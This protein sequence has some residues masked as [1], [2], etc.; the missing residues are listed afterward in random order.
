V[1]LRAP[2]WGSRLTAGSKAGGRSASGSGHVIP[3]LASLTARHHVIPVNPEDNFLGSLPV[4]ERVVETAD[5][6]V[7]DCAMSELIRIERF[8]SVSRRGTYII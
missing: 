2:K 8:D 6:F 5:L 7:D 3:R 4:I 1:V